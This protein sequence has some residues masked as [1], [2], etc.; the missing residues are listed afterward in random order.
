[1]ACVLQL[2]SPYAKCW[3]Y[4]RGLVRFKS[5]GRASRHAK[6]W[7]YERGVIRFNST[8]RAGMDSSID[9]FSLGYIGIQMQ[10]VRLGH[11]LVLVL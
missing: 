4:V 9:R 3:L 5:I 2:A 11:V 8:A 10:A 1:M 7:L 6:C